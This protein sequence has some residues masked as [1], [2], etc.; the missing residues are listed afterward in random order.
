MDFYFCLKFVSFPFFRENKISIR[1]KTSSS[2]EYRCLRSSSVTQITFKR[3]SSFYVLKNCSVRLI[4]V[5]FTLLLP[6][7]FAS[8]GRKLRWFRFSHFFNRL[9]DGEGERS[10]PGSP[11]GWLAGDLQTVPDRGAATRQVGVAAGFSNGETEKRHDD[12]DGGG[13]EL[14]QVTSPLPKPNISPLAIESRRRR[15]SFF[16]LPPSF[17]WILFGGKTCALKFC[18]GSLRITSSSI[19]RSLKYYYY[20][21]LR[22]RTIDRGI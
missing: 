4:F 6:C 12:D 14:Q 18:V 7:R 1:R 2:D 5:S 15:V 19:D 16:F 22:C 8:V 13:K 9:H 20:I 17:Q 10:S 21:E 11:A 3:T